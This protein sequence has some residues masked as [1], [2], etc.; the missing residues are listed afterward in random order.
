[1]SPGLLAVNFPGPQ[2]WQAPVGGL[3]GDTEPILRLVAAMLW[4]E[5]QGG[6]VGLLAAGGNQL[7]LRL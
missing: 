2:R 6:E 3:S 1:M 7:R 5:Q 4:C